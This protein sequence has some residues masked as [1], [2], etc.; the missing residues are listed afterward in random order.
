MRIAIIHVVSLTSISV[1][2]HSLERVNGGFRFEA[3]VSGLTHETILIL[4]F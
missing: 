1:K 3:A 4:E 2:T